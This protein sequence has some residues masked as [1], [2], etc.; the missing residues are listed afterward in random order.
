MLKPIG[1]A[2]AN[3]IAGMTYDDHQAQRYAE[4]A[5]R[6]RHLDCE[7]AVRKVIP[8]EDWF[9]PVMEAVARMTAGAHASI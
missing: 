8:N 6:L 1:I 9:G 4:A 5:L 3:V 7:S 2:F